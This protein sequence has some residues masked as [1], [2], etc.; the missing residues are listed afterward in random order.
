MIVSSIN[1][2][3]G[4][5]GNG[6]FDITASPNGGHGQAYSAG[7][8][9]NNTI[10]GGCQAD[11]ILLGN[12]SNQF[13]ADSVVSV[14]AASDQSRMANYASSDYIHLSEGRYFN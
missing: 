4:L 3:G 2:Y 14:S 9:S 6:T 10:A 11:V 13:Y 5:D 8:T 12:G 7:G 1:G